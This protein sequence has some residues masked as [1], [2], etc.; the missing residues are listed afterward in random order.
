MSF[1]TQPEVTGTFG[2][3]ASTHWLASQTAIGVALPDIKARM[4]AIGVAVVRSTP[5]DFAGVLQRDAYRYGKV[6]RELGVKK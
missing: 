4:D 3:A 1:T 2:V 6:I 5:Q